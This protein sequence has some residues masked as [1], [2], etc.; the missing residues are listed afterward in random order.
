MITRFRTPSDWPTRESLASIRHRKSTIGCCWHAPWKNECC[1]S[2]R[3]R[4]VP[5]EKTGPSIREKQKSLSESFDQTG[6]G[7]YPSW[8]SLK[9]PTW[10]TRSFAFCRLLSQTRPR[11]TGH[12]R[13]SSIL[14]S[15]R[16]LSQSSC[17]NSD[18]K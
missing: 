9:V 14:F 1:N 8:T 7:A 6:M 12:L 4:Y 11:L 13:I 18:C 15:T 5:Y 3:W 2:R 10:C 16:S 17:R